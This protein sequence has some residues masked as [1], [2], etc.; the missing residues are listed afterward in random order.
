MA[1]VEAAVMKLRRPT[2]AEY[3]ALEKRMSLISEKI[4]NLYKDVKILQARAILTSRRRTPLSSFME[5]KVSLMREL[6]ILGPQ[7]RV[8]C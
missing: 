7:L 5:Q 1:Q 6:G 4:T 8:K 3:L 2:W